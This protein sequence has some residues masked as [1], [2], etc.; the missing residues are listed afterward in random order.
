M[1]RSYQDYEPHYQY[2]TGEAYDSIE[3]QLKDF[4]KGQ[5]KVHQSSNGTLTV[6]GE[7]PLEGTKWIR[8]SKEF[9][10]PKDCKAK[11]IRARLSSGVL[12][13]AIPK[14]VTAT[15]TQ[16]TQQ[17]PQAPMR[18]ASSPAVQDKGKQKQEVIGSD[19]SKE[20]DADHT[21]AAKQSADARVVVSGT[22]PN[23]DAALAKVAGSKS[24]VSKIKM[25]RK[26]A[27]KVVAGVT[28]LAVMFTLLF[29]AYKFYAPMIMPAV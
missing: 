8:F 18:Q 10:P 28:V 6:S 24:F 9:N 11:E 7:R 23:G 20:A 22:P 19:R 17:D 26:T 3:L 16:V 4:T 1:C 13:I 5:L 25:E 12:Y 27:M 2:K 29:Y 21:F 15:T 14:K